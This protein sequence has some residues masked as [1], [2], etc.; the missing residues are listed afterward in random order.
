MTLWKEGKN[1]FRILLLI[2]III[3][4]CEIGVLIL[5]GQIIGIPWTILLIISTGIIGAWLAKKE[6]L[7]TIQLAQVQ[8]QNAQIP[9]EAILD[10]I[11]ILAGGLLLLTPGFIT[12]TTGFLLLVPTTRGIAK[13]WLRKLFKNWINKGNIQ[14]SI[15][16]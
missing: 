16:R 6:G 10:G 3:P 14:F 5:S 4:A 11:C 1:M 8:M 13:I 2:M 12:D 15:W 9:G 7:N